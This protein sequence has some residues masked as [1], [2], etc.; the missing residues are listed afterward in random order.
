M[1][2]RILLGLFIFVGVIS[3]TGCGSKE[4]LTCKSSSKLSENVTITRESTIT[5]KDDKVLEVETEEIFVSKSNDYLSA[6]KTAIESSY[7]TYDNLKYYEYN[8]KLDD[9]KLIT[10][11]KINYEK[12]DLAKFIKADG[13]NS[14]IIKEGKVSKDKL[15]KVYEDNQ[16]TC[17]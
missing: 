12:I 14:S 15:V 1:K 10:T 7:K 13:N 8:I 5:Y 17:K 16:M 11:T 2:K 9:D 6:Y 4:K 3:L